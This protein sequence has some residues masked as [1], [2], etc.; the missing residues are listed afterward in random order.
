MR[1]IQF[2]GS[3]LVSFYRYEVKPIGFLST[4][5]HLNQQRSRAEHVILTVVIEHA[6]KNDEKPPHK[7]AG[8]MN[9]MTGNGTRRWENACTSCAWESSCTGHMTSLWRH[10]QPFMASLN[11]NSREQL[12]KLPILRLNPP[13]INYIQNI[14]KEFVLH[15]KR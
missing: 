11:G 14:I 12:W 6:N 8:N 3:S 7:M 5:Q 4:A 15:N 13:F 10:G 9:Y 1:G 2:I